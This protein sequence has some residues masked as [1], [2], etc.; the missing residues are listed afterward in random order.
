MEKN[1]KSTKRNFN[2]EKHQRH[3]RT[4][5]KDISATNLHQ[6]TRIEYLGFTA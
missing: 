4:T 2:H 5:K 6:L 3:E 1:F